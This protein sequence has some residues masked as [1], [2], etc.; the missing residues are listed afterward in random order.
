MAISI[1][2]F[3]AD[4][5]AAFNTDVRHEGDGSEHLARASKALEQCREDIVAPGM[6]ALSCMGGSQRNTTVNCDA[7]SEGNELAVL[8]QHLLGER[9][10]RIQQAV[11]VSL[12]FLRG[13]IP[14]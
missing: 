1:F 5:I 3:H 2:E 4:G 10:G 8:V 6:V 13:R 14:P 11:K 12:R 7:R 9:K